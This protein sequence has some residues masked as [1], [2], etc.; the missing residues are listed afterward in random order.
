MPP[1]FRITRVPTRRRRFG[2]R[3]AGKLAFANPSLW[4]EYGLQA[5]R[6][7][8]APP[9]M[10]GVARSPETGSGITSGTVA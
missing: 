10:E 2:A 8:A 3:A 7:L 6:M 1:S 5:F 4:T 9:F